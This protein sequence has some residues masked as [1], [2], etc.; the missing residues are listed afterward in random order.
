[1][2]VRSINAFLNSRKDRQLKSA[3]RNKIEILNM[4]NPKE[5]AII[6]DKINERN[7]NE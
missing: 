2:R 1:M 5:I 4:R 7:Q 3:V 6:I